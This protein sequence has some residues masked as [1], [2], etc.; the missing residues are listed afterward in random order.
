MPLNKLKITV[1]YDSID[2]SSKATPSADLKSDS[3][4]RSVHEQ[5]ADALTKRGHQ[6]T[7]LRA[8]R[9]IR[10]LALQLEKD[11]SDV[12]FNVCDSLGGEDQ[13]EQRVASLLELLGKPFTGSHALALTLAQDA[14]LARKLLYFHQVPHPQ[15]VVLNTNTLADIPFPPLP[16][17]IRRGYHTARRDEFLVTTFQEL[18]QKVSE[19][20][21][22]DQAPLFIE[23]VIE[24]REFSLVLMGGDPPT[25]LP[26]VEW[27]LTRATSEQIKPTSS[28]EPWEDDSEVHQA[29]EL[30][31][32]DIP[33]SVSAAM[34]AAACTAYKALQIA[35]YAL[36][37]FKARYT[38][39]E[40]PTTT[41]K[42]STTLAHNHS[43]QY[44][45][46]WVFSLTA[47]HPKPSLDK[48]GIVATAARKQALKYPQLI[49]L[50][51]ENAITT[52]RRQLR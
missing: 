32:N 5:V 16:L 25:V 12:I 6:V 50:I 18:E 51:I 33:H 35:G 42:P 15:F 44:V 40:P 26:L 20:F 13:H 28:E 46:G 45:D 3:K 48:R 36:I 21:S 31:P 34:H 23:E 41:S 30:F 1:L 4:G 11:Q 7:L 2:D 24:G 8:E 19:L 43:L 52:H 22:G 38:G 10:A 39:S 47:V 9:K 29:V 14:T 49:E 17:Q 37:T 27:N